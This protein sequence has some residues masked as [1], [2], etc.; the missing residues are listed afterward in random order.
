[1]GLAMLAQAASYCRNLILPVL[2]GALLVCM[3][4]CVSTSRGRPV[5]YPSLPKETAK[6]SPLMEYDIGISD[7]LIVEAVRQVPKSPYLLQASD[8]VII[9]DYGDFG[10]EDEDFSILG[11]Y[12]IQPG[13]TIVL[14][15]PIG[16]VPVAG[17]SCEDAG[18]AIVQRIAQETGM[19]D[20]SY[21]GV[22]V[23]LLSISGMQPIAG[24]HAVG[25]DGRINLG[26]YGNVHVAGLTL[27]EAKDAIEFELSKYLDN[28]EVAVDIYSYN[29][30]HYYV[31]T[32]GAGFGDRL[33]EFP[34]TGNETVINAIAGV[35]GMDRVSSKRVWIAR[36]SPIYGYSESNILV[37]DWQAITANASYHT[38]YQLM[39]EDRIYIAEDKFVAFD[40][41][42]SKF[43]APF[44]RI[45]GFSLL[46]AQTA[47]RFSG[48]VLRG[49]GDPTGGRY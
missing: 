16:A 46:G 21:I 19:T 34:Y 3:V 32:Q 18:K 15:P 25:P 26:I 12:R 36:P 20:T 31:L 33:I 43:I 10:L 17:L 13:G 41:Q 14:P 9:K 30:K 38:N 11:S 47:T 2:G 24:E 39:P 35:N 40:T 5:V 8:G 44:E 28:P 29:S 7:V 22:T 6:T 1:M 23:E 42:L 49:G 37:V 48:N 4:G 45:M 27:T